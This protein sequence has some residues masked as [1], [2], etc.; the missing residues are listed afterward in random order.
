[1]SYLAELA[2]T[3]QFDKDALVCWETKD[4]RKIP[5]KDMETSHIRNTVRLLTDKLE[6]ESEE[7]GF[8]Y[9]NFGEPS[10]LDIEMCASAREW[11]RIFGK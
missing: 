8:S 9:R 1:M 10:K 11:L 4:G 5:I 2:A 7:M 6:R 3:G